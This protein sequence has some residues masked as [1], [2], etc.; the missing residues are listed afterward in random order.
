M[1]L[2]VE[3]EEEAA[4]AELSVRPEDEARAVAKIEGRCVGVVDLQGNTRC[5]RMLRNK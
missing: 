5:N 1:L 3:R 2:C 4:T